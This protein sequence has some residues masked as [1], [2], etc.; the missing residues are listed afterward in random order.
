MSLRCSG[1]LHSSVRLRASATKDW[2]WAGF[3]SAPGVRS[4]STSVLR[5]SPPLT[6]KKVRLG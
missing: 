3:Q 4:A 1:L 2:I 6:S 5:G